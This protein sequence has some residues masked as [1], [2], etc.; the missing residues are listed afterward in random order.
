MPST[1][2]H[3]P[4]AAAV[5]FYRRGQAAEAIASLGAALRRDPNRPLLWT[6]LAL[7]L[8]RSGRFAEAETAA[9]RA[10]TLAPRD[11][12]ALTNLALVFAA[13]ECFALAEATIAR[14]LAAAPDHGPALAGRG[15]IAERQAK[16]EDAGA[17]YAAAASRAPDYAEAH[18][19]HAFCL[20]RA[21][22]FAA[23]WDE[24][25]WRWRA[26]AFASSRRLLAMPE[27]DGAPLDGRAIFVWHEQG[28]GDTLQFAR[29]LPLLVERGARVV[30]AVQSPLVRLLAASMP[31]VEVV[32]S[33]APVATLDVHAPMLSL[34]RRFGTALSGVPAR[35]PYLRAASLMT[36]PDAAAPLKV[37]LAWAGAPENPN[38]RFRSVS[39]RDLAPILAVPGAAFYSL[40]LGGRAEDLREVAA[41]RPIVDLASRLIDFSDTAA[42]VAAVDLIVTVDTALA[43]LAG[44]LAKPVW[45]LIPTPA[46]WRWLAGRDDSPWYPTMRLFRQPRP[47]DWKTPI[48][49]IAGALAERVGR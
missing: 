20:L 47:G 5:E 33:K 16:L 3:R 31:M 38:D 25:E 40:Q 13:H 37:G 27:W 48:A 6:N 7:L 9:R 23:G 29:Y 28:L 46:D 36:L 42:A 26:E 1:D 14:A 45:T 2:I 34:P 17:A 39:L 19:N 43:H 18:V 4:A 12:D 22:E 35:A 8:F 49:D 15:F 21:G 11:P 10:V 30:A 44:G 24:Y 32:D 41:R